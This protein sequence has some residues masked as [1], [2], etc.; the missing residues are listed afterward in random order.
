M[1]GVVLTYGC[2]AF[3]WTEDHNKSAACFCFYISF[4][5]KQCISVF[6]R[7]DAD[8]GFFSQTAFGRQLGFIWIVFRYNVVTDLLI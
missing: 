3:A 7:D 6:N 8:T 4:I 2:K 5:T 1:L